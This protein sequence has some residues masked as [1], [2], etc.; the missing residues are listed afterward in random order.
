MGSWG[1]GAKAFLGEV[2]TR[3]KQATGNARSMEFLRQRISI[4]IQSGNAVAVMGT[5]NSPKEWEEL[6]VVLESDMDRFFKI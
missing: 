1:A 6:F 2:G 4:E 5:V 3:V